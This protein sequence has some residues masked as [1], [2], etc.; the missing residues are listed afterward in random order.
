MNN[1]AGY[2]HDSNGGNGGGIANVAGATLTLV[3]STI[4]SNQAG[5]GDAGGGYG[6]G[7]FNAAAGATVTGCTVSGNSAGYG[8]GDGS[9]GGIANGEGGAFT[10]TNSTVSGNQA[11]NY[12]GEG[13]GI[14]NAGSVVIA[15]CTISANSITGTS[16][17]GTG[18]GLVNAGPLAAVRNTLIAGNSSAPEWSQ[19]V[20][21]DCYGVLTSQGYNL[22]QDTSNCT[23]SGDTTGNITGVDPDLGPLQSNGGQTETQALLPGSPAIDAGNPN[24]CTDPDGNILTTDQ[25][26]APRALA[27]DARCDIGAYEATLPAWAT[28][29]PTPTATP[30]NT[31]PTPTVTPTPIPTL[32]PTATS[33]WAVAV[34]VGSAAGSPG[35]QVTVAVFLKSGSQSVAGIQNDIAFD[36]STPIT[37]TNDGVPACTVNPAIHEDAVFGPRCSALWP[38]SCSGIRALVFSLDDVSPIPD[39]SLLYTCSVTISSSAYPGTYVL[40]NSGVIAS[41]PSGHRLPAVGGADGSIVV[42]P[43]PTR[44]GT[45]TASPTPTGTASGPSGASAPMPTSPPTVSGAPA[46][47]SAPGAPA[48]SGGCSLA[49]ERDH[50][51]GTWLALLFVAGFLARRGAGSSGSR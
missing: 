23:I 9:G 5:S 28:I 8:T 6:G 18:S 48:G 35:Q 1:G 45:A 44:I 39:G 19:A 32:T 40:A 13:G 3:D 7:I 15:S 10:L 42:L 47:A 49:P 33:T 21:D 12:G 16:D 29:T 27:G 25:R 17:S 30:T 41:D 4:S 26:G 11:G 51:R 46:D 20:P 38:N 31:P 22:I 14:F 43:G 50:G 34:D 2:S 36:P 24:G 37:G